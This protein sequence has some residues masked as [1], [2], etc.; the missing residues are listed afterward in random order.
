MDRRTF[1]TTTSSVG[2]IGCA[3][4]W[5]DCYGVL[6]DSRE[7][8][9]VLFDATLEASR[10]YALVSATARAFRI[11]IGTDVGILW[12]RQL[13]DWPG[14]VRG[15]LRP[16]DCFVLST[17]SI[18]DGRAVRSERLGDGATVIDIG[19]RRRAL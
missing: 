7:R 10:A 17:L 13:R 9:A 5:L 12:H 8:V 19:R 11:E 18:A 14:A 16:S 6:S 4:P 3:L 1:V 2:L 15:V